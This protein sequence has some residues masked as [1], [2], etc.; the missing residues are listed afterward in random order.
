MYG[1]GTGGPIVLDVILKNV[2]DHK[3]SVGPKSYF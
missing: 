3:R 1:V 2:F